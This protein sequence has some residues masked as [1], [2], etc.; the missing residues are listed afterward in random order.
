VNSP[1]ALESAWMRKGC[2]CSCLLRD[3]ADIHW[4]KQIDGPLRLS[5][6]LLSWKQKAFYC[7]HKRRAVFIFHPSLLSTALACSLSKKGRHA[8][9]EELLFRAGSL[10]L[11]I[12]GTDNKESFDTCFKSG[13]AL[14]TLPRCLNVIWKLLKR[15]SIILTLFRHL[16]YPTVR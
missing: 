5:A 4:P 6:K 10:D 16:G 11:H 12:L 8:T 9:P 13:N 15:H 14:N 3:L 2:G 7:F 1:W